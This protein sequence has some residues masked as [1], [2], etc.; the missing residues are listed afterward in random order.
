MEEFK[1][2]S[3]LSVTAKVGFIKKEQASS[4]VSG[5]TVYIYI[6]INIYLTDIYAKNILHSI[7][8]S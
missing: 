5:S 4:A 3:S 7:K 6:H 2:F 1:V 8:V